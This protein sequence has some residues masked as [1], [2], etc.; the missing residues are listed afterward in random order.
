MSDEAF[1]L[2]GLLIFFAGVVAIVA[3]E[4]WHFMSRRGKA[5]DS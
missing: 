3:Y 2:T 4:I 5:T 1:I